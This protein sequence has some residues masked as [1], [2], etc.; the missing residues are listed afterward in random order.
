[1][2]RAFTIALTLIVGATALAI[3]IG[4]VAMLAYA[5]NYSKVVESQ[6]T[7]EQKN[8]P[9]VVVIDPG[10]GG[11][12]NGVSS[13]SG[14]REAEVNL[15]ISTLLRA[16]LELSGVI[17]VMTREDEAGLNDLDAPNKKRSDMRRRHAIIENAKPDL[18]ISIHVNSFPRQKSVHGIQTFYQ[19]GG[20]TGRTHAQAIQNYLN[21]T[22]LSDKKRVASSADFYILETPYPSVL[23]ECGFLSNPED[24]ANLRSDAYRKELAKHIATAIIKTLEEQSKGDTEASSRPLDWFD[25]SV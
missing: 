12:D 17:V 10:H 21:S 3:E 19:R 14:L 9:F 8:Q 22:D 13:A 2:K 16:E 18:V 5:I 7:I 4:T 25:I 1:M 15:E 23:I 24:E 11:K 20:E 6:A